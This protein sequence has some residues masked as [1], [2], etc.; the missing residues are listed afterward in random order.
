MKPAIRF[1][2]ILAGSIVIGALIYGGVRGAYAVAQALEL[3]PAFTN[4][5]P[6]GILGIVWVI[7][8]RLL[9]HFQRAA[10]QE[11]LPYDVQEKHREA[12]LQIKAQGKQRYVWRTGVLRW[13]LAV[14]AIWTPLMLIVGPRTHPL[15]LGEIIGVIVISLFLWTVG[16][17]VFGSWMWRTM[18]NKYR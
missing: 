11:S 13:G 12:W 17:Y 14:F 6:L 8:W 2:G 15:S 16:G 9:K 10:T 18:E 7:A 1:G 5:V 4:L 3:P